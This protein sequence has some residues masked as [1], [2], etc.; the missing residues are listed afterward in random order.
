[1]KPKKMSEENLWS[2]VTELRPDLP[3][4]WKAGVYFCRMYELRGLGG[5]VTACAD[6]YFG[7][8]KVS[9]HASFIAY[10][11]AIASPAYLR[12]ERSVA[13]KLKKL[14]YWQAEMDESDELRDGARFGK[15][16][17]LGDGVQKECAAL[18]AVFAGLGEQ[19][20]VA[21]RK[22]S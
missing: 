6:V 5:K 1:M 14:G 13:R 20:Q 17:L 22:D 3:P 8:G 21:G 19:K 2:A 16:L 15:D 10:P 4:R 11:E 12:M 7:E 18:D 9:L